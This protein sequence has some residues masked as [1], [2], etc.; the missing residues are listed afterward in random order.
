MSVVMSQAF[1]YNIK[2]HKMFCRE[3]ITDTMVHLNLL[4][5]DTV[6]NSYSPGSYAGGQHLQLL[7]GAS[8]AK[9][10]NFNYN[11]SS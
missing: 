7:D 9:E 1:L 3:L 8:L 4:P 11:K 5:Q 10:V 2:Y 6:I